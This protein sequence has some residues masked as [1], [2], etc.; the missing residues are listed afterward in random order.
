MF[1]RCACTQKAWLHARGALSPHRRR[2][3]SP[4][5]AP[6]STSVPPLS[7]RPPPTSANHYCRPSLAMTGRVAR[8]CGRGTAAD[9]RHR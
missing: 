3:R 7:H 6:Q 5:C 1:S 2:C 9:S 4:A 8:S